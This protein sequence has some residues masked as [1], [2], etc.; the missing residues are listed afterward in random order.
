[1]PLLG[2]KTRR[3]SSDIT[4]VTDEADAQAR[5]KS[6]AGLFS[7]GPKPGDRSMTISALGDVIFAEVGPRQSLA[8]GTD[9]Y[10]IGLRDQQM[11]LVTLR[12]GE[13]EVVNPD[14]LR[15][16]GDIYRRVK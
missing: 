7:T 14:T 8:A 4:L 5:Q 11:F 13:I 15:Y 12:S 6:V 10:R 16:Y 9:S 3:Q 1:M 2:S